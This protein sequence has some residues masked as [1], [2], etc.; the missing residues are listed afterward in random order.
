MAFRE[1]DYQTRA[2]GALDAYLEALGEEKGKTDK[3]AAFIEGKAAHCVAADF[4]I[5]GT[6]NIFRDGVSWTSI[7]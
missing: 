2:L 3:A 1:L 7:W 6:D 4:P 5:N